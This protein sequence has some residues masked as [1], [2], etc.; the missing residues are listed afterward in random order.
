M[1]QNL[2]NEKA[3]VYMIKSVLSS[4]I[5]F[6]SNFEKLNPNAGEHEVQE[7]GDQY[8]ISNG[9][10]SNKNTLDDMLRKQRGHIDV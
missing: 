8:N 6:S 5:S 9:F 2:R 1:Q 4:C 7:H 10:D 3:R